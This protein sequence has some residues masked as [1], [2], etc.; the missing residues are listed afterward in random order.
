MFESHP[1]FETPPDDTVIWRYVGLDKLLVLLC[2]QQLFLCR[3]DL[4]RDP[5]EGLWP[6][7]IRSMFP[8]DTRRTFN[9]IRKSF[10][11]SCWH[12][13]PHQSAAFWDQYGASRGIAI[14][15]TIGRLKQSVSDEARFFVGR[16]RYFDYGQVE[17]SQF[18][19]LN[20]L[21]PAFAKRRSFE[22]EREIR[23]L[24]WDVPNLQ[25][26]NPIDSMGLSV[27]PAVLIETVFLSPLTP[28]W[29][30][31]PLREMLRRFDLDMIPVLRS[32]LYDRVVD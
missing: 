15:S 28:P 9:E 6:D 20:A 16:V 12:E 24:V 23:V 1:H 25:A 2:T 4:F 21:F 14:K 18:G 22:H 26:T 19:F 30:L 27:D 31:A 32:E 29:M 13:N 10:Y 5:W 3:V 7:S 11:A 17:P 8:D